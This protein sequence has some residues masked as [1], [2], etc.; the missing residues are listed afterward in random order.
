MK[1]VERIARAV[2]KK[3]GR[4]DISRD[5]TQLTCMCCLFLNMFAQIKSSKDNK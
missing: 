3:C 2:C 4:D 5:K 1:I